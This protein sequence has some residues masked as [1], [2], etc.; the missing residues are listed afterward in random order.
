VYGLQNASYDTYTGEVS[1]SPGERWNVTGYYSHEKNGSSQVNNGT[2]NFPVNDIFTIR[3]ADDVDTAGAGAMFALVPNKA[4]LNLAGRSQNLKGTARFTTNPNSTYQLARASM[5]G[6]ADI[7]NAD[8]A[9]LTRLDASVDWVLTQKVTL[10]LGTWFEEYVF[11]DVD[12]E[13]LQNIYPTAFFL[14]LNDGSYH[15]NVGYVRLTYHW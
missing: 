8:N 7:P 6:V 10:T 3:L 12:T 4:M 11:S 5:G 1:V 9:K 13:G 15:A 14:A 2:S